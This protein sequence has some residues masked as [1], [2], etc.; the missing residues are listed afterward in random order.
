MSV[1]RYKARLVA[2]GFTLTYG[3][4]FQETFSLIAKINSI[5]VLLSLTVKSY[6][7]LHQ[8]DVKNAFLNGDFEEEVFMPLGF[9]KKLGSEKICRLKNFL[10][11][12]K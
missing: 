5:M 8:I 9:E 6:W 7:P 4:D 1:E 12:L 10:Y 3:I 2:K 11:E